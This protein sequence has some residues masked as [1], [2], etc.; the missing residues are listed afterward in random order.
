MKFKIIPIFLFLLSCTVTSTNIN[1]R[2]P[3]NAKGFAYIFNENDYNKII[4]NYKKTK[5]N[6]GKI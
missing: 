5:R 2:I 1:N 6:F 4:I 3:Y